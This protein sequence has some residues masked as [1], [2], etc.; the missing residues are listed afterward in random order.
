MERTVKTLRIALPILFIGFIAV[1]VL[2]FNRAKP[3]RDKSV[4]E[5]VTSTMRPVDRPQI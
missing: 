5:P 4:N 1:L 2:S 3:R